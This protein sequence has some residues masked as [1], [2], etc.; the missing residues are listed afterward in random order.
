[1][2]GQIPDDAPR[3]SPRSWFIVVILST[4]NFLLLLCIFLVLYSRGEKFSL[5]QSDLLALN[6]YVLQAFLAAIGIGLAVLGAVGFTALR[7]VAIRR[8]EAAATE[9][10]VEMMRI[11]QAKGTD[12]VQAPDLGGLPATE[13]REDETDV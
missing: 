3:I 11:L 1:M 7:S 5:S 10:V 2:A 4:F 13:N 12:P 8:A 9:R 6:L